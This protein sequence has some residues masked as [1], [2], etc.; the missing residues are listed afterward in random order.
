MTIGQ[1]IKIIR[2]IRGLTQKEL[3]L[4]CGFSDSTSDV[5]IR[6]YESDSR[7]PKE[8]TLRMIAEA[9]KVNYRLVFDSK[10]R[11]SE[12]VLYTL[13]ELE[14]VNELKIMDIDK[15]GRLTL[16]LRID[17][18]SGQLY[19]EWRVK[20]EDLEKGIISEEEYVKWKMDLD[21]GRVRLG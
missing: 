5:R 17:S 8:E 12:D 9:L 7:V 4:E 11:S 1:R 3:G 14:E 15:E 2:K 21:K 18:G 13:F 19:K 16:E 6:Q 20:R 10:I